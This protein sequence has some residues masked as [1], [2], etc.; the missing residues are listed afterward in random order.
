M[1]SG[2]HVFTRIP[3]VHRFQASGRRLKMAEMEVEG[4]SGRATDGY[5]LKEKHKVKCQ[6]GK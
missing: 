3:K 4:F 5:M 2:S 1:I 6:V